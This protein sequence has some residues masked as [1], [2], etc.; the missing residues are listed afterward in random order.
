MNQIS[1]QSERP[2][3]FR[4]NPKLD[5]WLRNE[6]TD[7]YVSEDSDKQIAKGFKRDGGFQGIS[8]NATYIVKRLT[9]EFGPIGV[10]W[11]VEIVDD[12]ML[13][14][15]PLLAADGHV[16]G[17]E[18][19]HRLRIRFWYMLD[20][21]RI[22]FTQFGQTTFVGRNKYGFF[23]DEEAPKKS[24]TDAVTKAAS[25]LGI[26][27]DIH[28]GLWD[29]N[30][31]TSNRKAEAEA[32]REEGERRAALAKPFAYVQSNGTVS[33]FK[34]AKD[35]AEGWQKRIATLT[36][37]GQTDTLRVLWDG[38]QE[39][40]EGTRKV[41]ADAVK[42]IE[43]RI[44]I[45][46]GEI[47]DE[48][49]PADAKPDAKGE[50]KGEAKAN[51]RAK[52]KDGAKPEVLRLWGLDGKVLELGRGR[53]GEEPIVRLIG[54]WEHYLRGCKTVEDAHK[55]RDGN[56]DFLTE[57]ADHHRASVNRILT[58]VEERVAELANASW[59]GPDTAANHGRE[60][61]GA[62]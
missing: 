59:P 37:N 46:F 15:A 20:G 36:K 62:A 40:L 48:A 38:N 35:W 52:P 44:R 1:P 32:E 7:I 16:I 3:R 24:L 54:G 58:M 26:A 61:A 55:L 25:W 23:T 47:K 28:M 11:G 10:G 5:L 45:A 2:S 34:D 57:I 41:A 30:K 18:L 4:D 51:A 49:P 50:A 8:P 56:R 14:G 17:R 39:A 19:V 43:R 33:R 60:T 31:Y 53:N 27:A 42:D 9:A 21:Q 29:D 6:V 22:E 12:S 13:E